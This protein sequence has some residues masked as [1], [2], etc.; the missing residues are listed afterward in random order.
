[1]IEIHIGAVEFIST[2]VLVIMFKLVKIGVEEEIR[3][4][5]KREETK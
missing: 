2:V 4:R 3:K 1:M 5:I